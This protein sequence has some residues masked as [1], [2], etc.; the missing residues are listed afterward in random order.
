[1]E[2]F[3]G[4]LEWREKNTSYGRVSVK[5]ARVYHRL[6][7]HDDAIEFARETRDSYARTMGEDHPETNEVDEEVRFGGTGGSYTMTERLA[8]I[9]HTLMR[10]DDSV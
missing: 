7:R 6:G 4:V 8:I 3:H 10:V 1:M 9:R 5:L 2:C